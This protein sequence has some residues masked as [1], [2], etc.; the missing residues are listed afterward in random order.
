VGDSTLPE[1]RNRFL[2]S[3]NLDQL[4]ALQ[5]IELVELPVDQIVYRQDEPITHMI[6]VESGL[7]STLRHV[8]ERPEPVELWSFGGLFGFLGTHTLLHRAESI[9][10]Y[11][12]RIAVTGWSVPREAIHGL[13]VD[14]LEFSLRMQAHVR[15]GYAEIAN[16]AACMAIHSQEQRL[17]RLMLLI[18]QAVGTDR[19]SL[20]RRVLRGMV[21]MS[22]T[23]IFQVGRRLGGLVTIEREHFEIHD[24]AGLD[25][26]ACGCLRGTYEARGAITD[27]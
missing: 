10:E 16:V 11:R 7:I 4:A 19:V 15:N 3:F 25:A 18:A 20:R 2:R 27:L 13:M 1:Y 22:R 9:Y 26:R 8:R 24:R 5:P 23:H 6:F 17:C 12:T 14:D 21:G